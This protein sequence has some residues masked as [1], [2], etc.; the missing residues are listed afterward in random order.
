MDL[1]MGRFR[2]LLILMLVAAVDLGSPVLPQASEAAE[3]FEET[4][5]ARRRVLRLVHTEAPHAGRR[6]QGRAGGPAPAPRG[7]RRGPAP[8]PSG[9]CRR[10]CPSPRPRSDDH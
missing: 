1:Y 6:A 8:R 10:P 9:S 2:L 5:H 3:E 4:T 7:P